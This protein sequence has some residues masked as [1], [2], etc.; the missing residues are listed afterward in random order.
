MEHLLK[1]GVI[2]SELYFNKYWTLAEVRATTRRE[3]SSEKSKQREKKKSHR[4]LEEAKKNNALISF[5]HAKIERKSFCNSQNENERRSCSAHR[6][7]VQG[8]ESLW[9]DCRFILADWGSQ[10]QICAILLFLKTFRCKNDKKQY[11]HFLY[12]K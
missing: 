7:S 2:C 1:E 3:G 10:L 12:E 6:V 5:T 8:V 11:F 9:G 4:F